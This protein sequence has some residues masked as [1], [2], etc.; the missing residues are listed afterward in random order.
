MEEARPHSVAQVRDFLDGATEIAFRVPKLERYS[1]VERV[2]MRFG[3]AKAGR[4]SK[5]VLLR[6]LALLTGLLRQ[7]VSG[8]VR[9]HRQEG[10]LSTRPGP[11][12]HGF[13]RRFTATNVALLADMDARHGTVSGPTTKTL[14][15][16]AGR[17]FGNARFERLAG[18]SVS[19]LYN[20]WGRTPSQR[21]RRHWTQTR[22][23]GVPIGQRRAP[24]L[25]GMPGYIRIDSVH[26]GDQGGMNGVYH[27]N[28][29]DSVTPFQLVATCEKYQ[30][31]LFAAGHPAAV[32]ER[33]VCHPR[34]PRGER[35]RVHHVQGGHVVREV[36]YRV[37]HVP[38]PAFQR[39]RAGGTQEWRGGVETLG[40]CAHPATVRRIG[41]HV[42]YASPQPVHQ[43]SPS[44]P[45][46]GDDHRCQ[47]KGAHA[48]SREGHKN[49]G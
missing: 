48:R 28:A 40:V 22:S 15:K 43:L 2:L 20:L 7:Q 29:V 39:Q 23:T 42:L 46:S 34:I 44:G 36:A 3:Y 21:P 38:P 37:H 33:S 24:Q 45:L 11:P 12:Q 26:Q 14:R 10:T 1:F 13:R 17:L 9:R 5:G 4:V 16:R 27:H 30:R 6:Y 41:Q 19:H 31:G 49:A 32:R 25:N 8:V 47:G 35:L 18:I